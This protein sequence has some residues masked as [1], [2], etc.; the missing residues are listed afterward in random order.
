MSKDN[1]RHELI[2]STHLHTTLNVKDLRPSKHYPLSEIMNL[3][4]RSWR[5]ILHYSQIQHYNITLYWLLILYHMSKQYYNPHCVL[6]KWCKM[7]T[8]FIPSACSK[9]K[10][11]IQFLQSAWTVRGTVHLFIGK[12]RSPRKSTFMTLTST[13][14]SSTNI[15]D[16]QVFS[17]LTQC[18]V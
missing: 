13:H 16:K 3:R 1:S 2:T 15:K 9:V 4:R 18:H 7:Y 5:T 10:V 14:Y 8:T 17:L 11:Q 6:T 12:G